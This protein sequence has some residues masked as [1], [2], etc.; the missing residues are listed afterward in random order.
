MTSQ[1]THA[2]VQAVRCIYENGQPAT[3]TSTTE[4]FH[5]PCYLDTSLNKDILLLDDIASAFRGDIVHIRSGTIILPCL[6]GPDFN[7]LVPLRVAAVSGVTL[8]V[9]IRSQ[10]SEKGMSMDS[11]QETLPGTRQESIINHN[12][13]SNAARRNPVGGLVEVAMD[14]YRNNDNPAF[15][16]RLRGPQAIMDD[17]PPPSVCD[18]PPVS[19][20][21]VSS[22]Q[23]S[24]LQESACTTNK[25]DKADGETLKMAESGDRDAQFALG[26]MYQYDGRLSQDYQAAMDWYL[27]AAH[28]GHASAQHNIG[29][30]Y[31]YGY[32]VPQD[33]FQAMIW[34]RKAAYQGDATAQYFVAWLYENG[35]GVSE[36]RVKA[37]EWYRKAIAGGDEDAKVC[38]YRLEHQNSDSVTGEKKR[39]L[40]E[41]LFK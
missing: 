30:L 33:Y 11:L 40:F 32:G 7:N 2:N 35:L 18:I 10:A 12:S 26:L 37:I 27:K 14:A 31:H 17:P 28:Q 4:V 13:N 24:A 1:E 5:L 21:S 6:K 39:G 22:S 23:T 16:P 15:G 9:V 20:H 19:Q 8:D 3:S 29:V 38:L 36:D 34:F 25:A 41:W